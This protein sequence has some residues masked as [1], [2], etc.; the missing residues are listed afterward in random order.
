MFGDHHCYEH[1]TST[2]G[3]R[4]YVTVICSQQIDNFIEMCNLM[5]EEFQ[6]QR[7]SYRI[8]FNLSFGW[9][10]LSSFRTEID[11]RLLSRNE[12]SF[13]SMMRRNN[14]RLEASFYIFY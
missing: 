12:N 2:C 7:L 6:L 4:I 14:S 9:I 3:R 11:T 10:S 1:F 13:N 8:P 5:G